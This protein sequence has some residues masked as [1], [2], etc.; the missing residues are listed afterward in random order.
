MFSKCFIYEYSSM[1]QNKSSNEEKKIWW[2]KGR[3]KD[4]DREIVCVL[5]ENVSKWEKDCGD[6][7]GRW[8]REPQEIRLPMRT[9]SCNVCSSFRLFNFHFPYL[10]WGLVHEKYAQM[11]WN[12]SPHAMVPPQFAHTLTNTNKRAN[13]FCCCFCLPEWSAQIASL[14]R[15]ARI[16]GWVSEWIE[17]IAATQYRKCS[18]KFK[19]VR[20]QLENNFQMK[21][22]W[23]RLLVE[24]TSKGMGKQVVYTVHDLV[25]HL[26]RLAYKVYKRTRRQTDA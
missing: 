19:C 4:T 7:K 11:F 10:N 17:S 23:F 22:N 18:S 26:Q 1:V 8:R 9:F 16:G 14:E 25:F 6:G 5:D 12:F 2:K 15:C 20:T 24:R 21:S 13:I 3:E